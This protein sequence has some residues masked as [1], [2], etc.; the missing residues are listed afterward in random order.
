MEL[1]HR[2]SLVGSHASLRAPLT[3]EVTVPPSQPI[4]TYNDGTGIN[5][6]IQASIYSVANSLLI[7]SPE[8]TVRNANGEPVVFPVMPT[9]I[10]VWPSDNP[11]DRT[12]T[13]AIIPGADRRSLLQDA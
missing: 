7:G 11:I 9:V 10:S 2:D 5:A 1:L 8:I 4:K 13:A 12:S 3:L 6:E